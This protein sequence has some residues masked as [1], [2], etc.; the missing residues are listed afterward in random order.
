MN[1]NVMISCAGKQFPLMEAFRNAIGDQGKLVASDMNPYAAAM[2]AADRSII[3][4]CLSDKK[5]GDWA[6][7]VSRDHNIGMWFSLLEDEL[8]VLEGLRD[9]LK[10]V[11][12]HLVGAPKD[13]IQNALNKQ[14]YTSFLG[15]HGINV[16]NTFTL[17]EL[18]KK[19]DIKEGKYIVKKRHGR[20]SFGLLR[21]NDVQA[22]I[23]IA[24]EK[25]YSD[26]WIAQP[27]I[28]GDIYCIDVIND[29]KGNFVCS[30]IRKRISMG[31]RETDIAETVDHAEI[32][33]IAK[34]LSEIIGHQGCMD[35]DVI[36]RE[37]EYFV[38]D[39]NVRFGGSHIFSLAAGA[40]IPA[41]LLAWRNNRAPDVDWLKHDSGKIWSRY[42]TVTEYIPNNLSI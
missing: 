22:L 20:G 10:E 28:D 39:L 4:P 24:K 25:E 18:T 16:P 26:D 3:S 34:K 37:E 27:A 19:N 31:T 9:R 14:S 12:C 7:Q 2:T 35:V 11:G 23:E 41:A 33:S 29:L 36:K 21:V 17:K 38:I 32:N 15:G 5:Y 6:I 40:N 42:S 8:L 13:K 30:L 1:Y